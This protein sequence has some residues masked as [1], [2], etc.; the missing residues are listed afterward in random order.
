LCPGFQTQARHPLEVLPVVSESRE[1]V[2]QGGG[3]N[4]EIKI[5]NDETGGV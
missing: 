5:A 1:I 3:C 2:Q 4:E